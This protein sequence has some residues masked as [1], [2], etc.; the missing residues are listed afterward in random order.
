MSIGEV[1]IAFV[2][3]SLSIFI[4][5]SAISGIFTSI[6]SA[7][8]AAASTI[9]NY[10]RRLPHGPGPLALLNR[11]VIWTS[12]MQSFSVMLS[13]LETLSPMALDAVIST[14]IPYI[15]RGREITHLQ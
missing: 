14:L 13:C 1:V 12:K 2:V 6:I 15:K 8:S 11:N 3:F 4:T 9:H 5:T 10:S 7:V